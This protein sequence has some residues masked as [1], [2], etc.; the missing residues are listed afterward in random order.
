[1]EE[2]FRGV[3]TE[4]KVTKCPRSINT[5]LCL[6]PYVQ[7]S[8]VGRSCMQISSCL[9]RVNAHLFGINIDK[10]VKGFHNRKHTV[11]NKSIIIC[12]L[13]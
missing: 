4:E 3:L 12:P 7:E 2:S 13:V 9:K 1:V 11:I 10:P 6:F 5:I 8:C